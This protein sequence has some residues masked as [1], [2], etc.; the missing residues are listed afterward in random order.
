MTGLVAVLLVS[1]TGC[2]TLGG[3]G[4]SFGAGDAAVAAA[5]QSLELGDEVRVS[6]G[7]TKI[8]GQVVERSAD[9]VI[10]LQSDARAER[11]PRRAIREVQVPIRRK[12]LGL[13]F[14]LGGAVLGGVVGYQTDFPTGE[15]RAGQG[16]F[17]NPGLAGIM[18]S[19]AGVGVGA[20]F[21]IDSWA[22]I[23]RSGG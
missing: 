15:D 22:T 1:L 18:G 8:A 23:A 14:G 20:L 2:A 16:K 11:I 10:I 5:L 12:S 19:L 21:G 9:E 13:P 17:V 7:R 3:P 4:E 6:L